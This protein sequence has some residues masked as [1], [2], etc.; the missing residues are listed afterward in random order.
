MT[1]GGD[2][3]PTVSVVV[4][5][6]DRPVKAAAVVRAVLDGTAV[7]L[8]IVVV[9]Q[10]RGDATAAALAALGDER[11]RLLFHEPPSC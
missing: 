4:P 8:E 7:P 2:P 5:T 3:G 6:L 1:S 9:D 10:S 11:V